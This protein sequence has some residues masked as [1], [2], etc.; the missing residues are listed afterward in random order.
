VI[1]QTAEY[2]LRA[3]VCLAKHDGRSLTVQEVAAEAKVPPGYLAKVLQA[4]AR[5]GIVSSRRGLG[6]GFTLA[7]PPAALTVLDVV[8]AVDPI[9]RIRACPLDLPEHA[10]KLCPLH[11]R[12]DAAAGLIEQSFDGATLAAMIEDDPVSKR[13]RGRS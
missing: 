10:H 3:A 11:A 7:A 1:S 13:R 4:L 2:A 12:L 5:S 6:G 9:P 8:N